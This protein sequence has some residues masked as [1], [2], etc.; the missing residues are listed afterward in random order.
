MKKLL[1]AIL[2]WNKWTRKINKPYLTDED[3]DGLEID[4]EKDLHINEPAGKVY[5]H[6]NNKY[7]RN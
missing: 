5:K 1:N 4:I 3:L 7:G 6:K 2:F